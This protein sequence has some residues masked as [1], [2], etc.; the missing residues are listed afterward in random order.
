MSSVDDQTYGLTLPTQ[1]QL[2]LDIKERGGINRL[3][4]DSLQEEKSDEYGSKGTRRHRQVQNKIDDWKRRPARY[5][6]HQLEILGEVFDHLSISPTKEY[7]PPTKVT[8]VATPKLSQKMADK[9]TSNKLESYEI[10][11]DFPENHGGDIFV[12]GFL[13]HKYDA[14]R[15]PAFK[16]MVL[17]DGYNFVTWGD[18]RYYK[19]GLYKLEVTSDEKVTAEIPAFP[20]DFIYDFEQQER[21]AAFL[22]IPDAVCT[23]QITQRGIIKRNTNR[24]TKKVDFTM[25]K[26]IKVTK[27]VFDNSDLKDVGKIPSIPTPYGGN[28]VRIDWLVS[29][30]ES[31]ER[32]AENYKEPPKELTEEEKL[33]LAEKL[34]KG[35]STS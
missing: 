2:L 15:N 14:N 5:E 17:C 35:M 32:L 22:G 3:N 23:S 10:N 19:R 9:P 33:E 24:I 6:K 26:G 20:Y 4:L 27:K 18:M 25:P 13:N 31:E 11:A 21:C 29:I 34:I 1:K 12:F 28:L 7:T 16:K 30:V 8:K